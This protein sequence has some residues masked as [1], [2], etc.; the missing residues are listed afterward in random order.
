ML[1]L[2]FTVIK[3][4]GGGVGE[5]YINE[6]QDKTISTVR[7]ELI[8]GAKHPFILKDRSIY[9]DWV[10]NKYTHLEPDYT[11]IQVMYINYVIND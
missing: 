9:Y 11:N 10:E 6:N 2:V 3:K 7:K 4:G 5:T 8:F 1:N